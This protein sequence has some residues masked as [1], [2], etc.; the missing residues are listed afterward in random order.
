M[1]LSIQ[2]VSAIAAKSH[3]DFGH[4][5]TDGGQEPTRLSSE[6]FD[7]A[8]RRWRLIADVSGLRS[9]TH[10]LAN[11]HGYLVDDVTGCTVGIVDDVVAH[12]TAGWVLAVVGTRRRRLVVPVTDVVEIEPRD[13]RLVVLRRAS[14]IVD[15]PVRLPLLRRLHGI[16]SGH[17]GFAIGALDTTAITA[18]R[19]APAEA[20]R[21]QTVARMPGWWSTFVA[22]P[23]VLP[24]TWRMAWHDV[25]RNLRRTLATMLGTVFTLVLVLVA[26]GLLT[27]FTDAIQVKY[28][29]VERQDATVVVDLKATDPAA[30]LRGVPGVA[31]VEQIAVG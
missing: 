23:R 24:V 9:P 17:R 12:P 10:W 22:R 18:A 29:Q 4:Q 2:E 28:H 26:V 13:R 6:R 31:A 5:A 11:C 3:D 21:N 14:E 7:D 25:F 1:R 16:G 30:L 8:G 20:M 15:R 27:G 19:T